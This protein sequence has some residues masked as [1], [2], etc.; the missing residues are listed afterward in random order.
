MPTQQELNDKYKDNL[1]IG[2][3]SLIPRDQFGNISIN[4]TDTTR[5]VLIERV[6]WVFDNPSI[7]KVIETRFSYYKFPP[8]IKITEVEDVPI[9]TLVNIDTILGNANTVNIM[10]KPVNQFNIPYMQSKVNISA[11]KEFSVTYQKD[12]NRAEAELKLGDK[13]SGR[14]NLITTKAA[15]GTDMP[16]L[17]VRSL[18]E[19]SFREIPFTTQLDGNPMI[20]PGRFVVTKDII[21][22][23]KNIKFNVNI[24]LNHLCNETRILGRLIRYRNN[25]SN[26][27]DVIAGY[28]HL[29]LTR[30]SKYTENVIW[31]NTTDKD[32][33]LQSGLDSLLTIKDKAYTDA[34]SKEYKVIIDNYE[35]AKRNYTTSSTENERLYR[36]L[37]ENELTDKDNK[38]VLNTLNTRVKEFAKFNLDNRGLDRNGNTEAYSLFNYRNGSSAKVVAFGDVVFNLILNEGF[39]WTSYIGTANEASFER[40]KIID[41][42]GLE[43]PTIE[44]WFRYTVN[45]QGYPIG[46][47][48]ELEDV[49]GQY[50]GISINKR[51]E[52][53]VLYKEI[54]RL[55]DL[56]NNKSFY[57]N[58]IAAYDKAKSE[59]ETY[60]TNTFLPAQN[61]YNTTK[62]LY[63]TEKARVQTIDEYEQILNGSIAHLN[64][65]SSILNFSYIVDKRDLKLYD[66]Y[67]VE[68]LSAFNDSSIDE[69][70]IKYRPELIEDSTYWSILST[71]EIASSIDDWFTGGTGTE[72][73]GVGEV[74]GTVDDVTRLPNP[75][76]QA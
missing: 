67:A 33:F 24:S 53:N 16:S 1:A 35:T 25:N 54:G 43:I 27:Y 50:L 72:T 21:D 66:I 75:E 18:Y 56:A 55:I 11:N 26:F 3:L 70:T 7:N 42:S 39:M 41:K 73:G 32:I 57:T 48:L 51:A 23:N 10:L 46:P 45:A 20:N 4:A 8:K 76:T 71:N 36:I 44:Y 37:T 28:S 34:A 12:I 30:N 15:D 62:K 68:I 40:L 63:E 19:G 64:P 22:S 9:D 60:N 31:K 2:S 69:N 14:Y 58:N 6:N 47:S 29:D 52:L 61:T 65:G 13:S 49:F 74:G 38:R 17:S 5:D 59:Y